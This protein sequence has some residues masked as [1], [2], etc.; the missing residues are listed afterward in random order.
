DF[1]VGETYKKKVI[2]TNVSY[3][4]NHLKLVGV[5]A[6]LHD[7]ISI[8]FERPGPLSTGM[9]FDIQA[10]FQPT[11]NEDLEG[12]VQ[13]ASTM[14]QFSVPVRCSKKKCELEVD[15]Q[16]I[17][18]GSHIVGQTISRTITLSNKGALA[19]LFSLDTSTSP[20][21]A[22]R[23]AQMT[24]KDSA[25][26]QNMTLNDQPISTSVSTGEL[27]P[28]QLEQDLSVASQQTHPGQ[29]I[30]HTCTYNESQ[31]DAS[32]IS[33]GNVREGQIGPSESI[34]LELVFTPTIPGEARLDFS[35]KFSDSSLDSIP[36]K[37]RGVAVS[38]PV[39]VVQPN[40]DMRICMFDHFYQDMIM[41]QS[42]ATAA[43][44]LTFEVC[45]EM[46]KHME[47]LPK[48]GFIQAQSSF[49][50]QL[51]F[52]PRISL[53]K[54]ASKYF[55]SDTG[56]WRFRCQCKSLA[57]S[58]QYIEARISLL[59]SFTRRY[60]EHT[61]P[62]FVSDGDPPEEDR[63]AQP[64]WSPINTLHLQLQCA[65]V[66]PPLVVVSSQTHNNIHFNQ[67][68]VGD[69]V[70][71]KITVQNIS[72]EYLE[73]RSSLLDFYGPF[74]LLNALRVLRP[75]QQFTLVLAFT[76]ALEKKYCEVL[77]VRCKRMNLELTLHGEGVIP[78][79]TS[80][81][82]GGLFDFGYVL[83][84]ES[85]SQVVQLQ[86]S[87]PVPVSFQVLLFST[88]QP[89]DGDD[90]AAH[91][92]SLVSHT[93]TQNYSGCSVFSVVP[94]EGSIAAGQSLDINVTFQP[95]H[96]SINYSDRLTIKLMNKIELCVL[97]LRGAASSRLMYLHGGDRLTVPV[98]SLL[99]P[100]LTTKS[101]V[102]EKPTIPALV[103]LRAS[104]SQGIVRPAVRVLQ[105][106]CIRSMQASKKSGEFHWDN[107]VSLQQQGFTVEPGRGSVEAGHAHT[108]TVTWT[109]QCGYK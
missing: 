56:S 46:R 87:S 4:T 8:N 68:S 64:A 25:N 24:F 97:D 32:D 42:R 96:P 47:I 12:E 36:I 78:S 15:S 101:R 6:K 16:F 53:P 104:Y 73:L 51:K 2:L 14:G 90:K 55:D 58:Q 85:S 48:T 3:I 27:Q 100:L 98:E 26:I 80:S 43:L 84:K 20:I 62:C 93:G 69:K 83:E 17:D 52:L 60:S 49:N 109:P 7:F 11:I 35:I 33:L 92:L 63:Q 77:E 89:Q 70:T 44:M 82:P 45:L 65:A 22:T 81:H 41:V 95:D 106:G 75:G 79:V 29:Y 38:A 99:P 72:K 61:I 5:S 103:T 74:M 86:N 30:L 31:T 105:V 57:W 102:M 107:L 67:V 94:V 10:V 91:L 37:A 39:W 50:A 9:S 28:K 18:F 108:I 66:Q 76:P 71:K 1:Q 59:Y 13:F 19:T 54:D 21:P 40:I 34:K 23:H 88:S